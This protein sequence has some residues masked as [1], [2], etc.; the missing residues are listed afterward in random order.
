MFSTLSSMRNRPVRFLAGFACLLLPVACLKTPP[1]V[2]L[3]VVIASGKFEDGLV[4]ELLRAELTST[5]TYAREVRGAWFWSTRSTRATGLR[6]GGI[7]IDWDRKVVDGQLSEASMELQGREA[8]LFHL[9]LR[10]RRPDGSGLRNEEVWMNGS[11]HAIHREQGDL[12][13]VNDRG[14]GA[15]DPANM[16][17]HLQVEDG[18]GG[19]RDLIGPLMPTTEDGRAFV[20]G[21]AIPRRQPML[22]L[23]A[24]HERQPPVE[25][26]VPN[27]GHQPSFARL[28]SQPMPAVHDGGEFQVRC[29]GLK[30]LSG[31]SQP[32]L[33]DA[34]LHLEAPR[35]PKDCLKLQHLLLDETGNCY[36]RRGDLT[37]GFAPLPGD[38]NL[39]V[40]V[41]VE[42]E[43]SIYPWREEEVTILAEGRLADAAG[44]QKAEITAIGRQ[45]GCT[46][47]E[48]QSPDPASRSWRF[49]KPYVLD[50]KIRGACTP[51]Q[52]AITQ[53][54]HEGRALVVFGE[55]QR[56]IGE[57]QSPSS[58]STS[59]PGNQATFYMDAKWA[60]DLKPGERFRVGWLKKC[61]PKRVDFVVEVPEK[62]VGKGR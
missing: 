24:L 38:Q 1:P 10:V 58:G 20:F 26:S 30:W 36:L 53:K 51:E 57:C 29:D 41:S 2:P 44:Q 61:Q 42:R 13:E 60:G 27:P 3:E 4:V 35:L 15:D 17:L 14:T 31:T 33:L 7:G 50:F 5:M 39:L 8:P 21:D 46:S 11:R 25:F 6:L 40:R 56:A 34:T 23:R 43:A 9:L 49:A 28:E 16:E 12:S 22:R 62:P 18:Q 59:G 52:L 45:L 48:F 32:S 47:I 54:A 55:G 37:R 19:W